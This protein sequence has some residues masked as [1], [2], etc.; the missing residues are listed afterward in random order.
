MLL[1]FPSCHRLHLLGHRKLAKSLMLGWY[2]HLV[3]LYHVLL[4]KTPERSVVRTG[5]EPIPKS[6]FRPSSRNRASTIPPPDC[7]KKRNFPSTL[8]VVLDFTEHSLLFTCCKCTTEQGP[9]HNTLGH[10]LYWVITPTSQGLFQ[11]C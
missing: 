2:I 10:V 8:T 6:C 7:F 1:V 3:H 5:F 11:R 4:L 9:S